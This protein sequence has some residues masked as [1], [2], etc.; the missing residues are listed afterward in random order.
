[1]SHAETIQ[2]FAPQLI[3]FNQQ[4]KQILQITIQCSVL[5]KLTL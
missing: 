1:M 5:N 4:I 3:N 2:N